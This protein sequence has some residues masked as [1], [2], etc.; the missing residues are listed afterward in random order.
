M[1]FDYGNLRLIWWLLLGVLLIGFAVMDGFD[2]GAAALLPFIGKND[3]ERR[4]IIN[5]V[6]PV[7][8]GN[9]VW[10]ILGGGA[11]FA[12]F[13]YLYAV[14]FSGFYLAMFIVLFS[15]ILR[16][17]GFKF[18][19]KMAGT[20]W[21]SL[22]DWCLFIGGAVPPAIFG[23]AFGNAILG[24]PYT[25]DDTMRMTYSGSFFGLLNPF[26]LLCGAISL[27]MVVQQGA[28]WL[29]LKTEGSIER[30]ARQTAA[31]F[32]MATP[33]LF[34]AAG[35]W[36][37]SG[38]AGYHIASAVDPGGPSNPML[39]TVTRATGAWMDNYAHMP[40][41]ILVPILMALGEGLTLIGLASRRDLIAFIGSSMAEMGIIG[42]AGV[43]MFP[44]LLPSSLNPNASLTIWDASSS[45]TTLIVMTL[46]VAIFMPIIIGYTGWVYYKLRGKITVSFVKEQG[47]SLY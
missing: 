22:W 8:E 20:G 47:D 15:L 13:P 43:S 18:R 30:R 6:G 7:W 44:F 35:L 5:T 25:F 33:L 4:V 19:S 27:F 34:L 40:V 36:V 1:I 16:P 37:G 42:T 28:C 26:A 12:A 3:G 31:F 39:K 17:V 2:M 14:A 46:S 41:L 29:S 21:R 11:V 23:V 24:V 45:R 32:A 10:L 38:I 9:Q